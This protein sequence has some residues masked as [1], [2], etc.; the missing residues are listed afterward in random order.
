[1]SMNAPHPSATLYSLERGV[2]TITL[3]RPENRNAL[4]IELVDSLGR[5]LDR[6]LADPA[7]RVVVL[8][9]VGNTFCAGADLKAALASGASAQPTSDRSFL[10]IFDL[11]LDSPKPIVGRLAGHCLAGGLGL[12]ASCDI[13]IAAADATFGFTEVRI[14]VA[15]AVISVVCLPKL[16]RA[17]ALELFLTGERISA[18]RAADVGLINRAVPRAELDNSVAELVGK[19]VAG[20]PNALAVSKQLIARVPGMSRQ[21]GFAYTGPLSASLFASAEGQEGIGAF[22]AKRP[23]SWIPQ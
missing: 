19:I 3:N 1:M 15:P 23:A 21:D 8:T 11:I 22:R 2:A 12:A 6:A 10:D 4:S 16:R 20:G 7:A 18:Q 17:D 5:D 14:G 9:N 13:S